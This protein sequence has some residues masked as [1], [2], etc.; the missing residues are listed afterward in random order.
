MK[1]YRRSA[2]R[3]PRWAQENC[4]ESNLIAVGKE[5]DMLSSD[6]L[7]MPVRKDQLP[8]DLRCFK[9]TQK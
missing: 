5:D 8:P 7:L 2:N 1:N 9:Q 6:G 4:S 3:R